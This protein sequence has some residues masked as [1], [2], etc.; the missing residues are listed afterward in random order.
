MNTLGPRPG[1]ISGHGVGPVAGA[2]LRS[3]SSAPAAGRWPR[4]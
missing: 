2:D 1:R 4:P 3:R